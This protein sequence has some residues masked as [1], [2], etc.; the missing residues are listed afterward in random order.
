MLSPKFLESR[1]ATWEFRVSLIHAFNERRS[2]VLVIIYGDVSLID[3]L[4]EDLKTYVKYNTYLDAEDR[5][6]HEKLL[7]AMPHKE[8]RLK[9]EKKNKNK[10][11]KGHSISLQ[12]IHS[13]IYEHNN[14][15]SISDSD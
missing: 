14:Q 6:F 13:S 15:L 1:W 2:R 7:Y 5:W 3:D 12:S 8:D 11:K 9:M 10:L 4:D